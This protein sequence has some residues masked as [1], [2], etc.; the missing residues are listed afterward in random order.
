MRKLRKF[1]ACVVFEW[2]PRL[3]P[4]PNRYTSST[5]V[6]L[7]VCMPVYACLCL[8]VCVC[9]LQADGSVGGLLIRGGRVVNDDVSYDA[10]VYVIDGKIA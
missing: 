8:C 1:F 7:S 4:T 3:S 9:G 6:C 10:D 5:P 2:K